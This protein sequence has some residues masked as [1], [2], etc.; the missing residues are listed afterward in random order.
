MIGLAIT[1]D[2]SLRSFAGILSSPVALD[3]FNFDSSWRTKLALTSCRAKSLLTL[4]AKILGKAGSLKTLHRFFAI[5]VKNLLK[6][7]ADIVSDPPGADFFCFG[8]IL[9]SVRHIS[10]EL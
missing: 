5:D 8:K 1:E 9:F 2:A 6:F 10:L 4:G 7:V 3:D